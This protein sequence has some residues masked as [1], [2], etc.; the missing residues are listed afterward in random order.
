MRVLTLG[1]FDIPHYGH[2]RF[3]NKCRL[4]GDV[5][6]GLNTD[7]F[8][9]KYKGKKPIFSYQERITTLSEWGFNNIFPNNQSDGTIKDVIE[10][11][12]PEI[13]IIGSDWLRKDYLSQIGIDPDYLDDKNLSLI[14]VPYTWS[15]SSSEI[16]RRIE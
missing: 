14:Y 10:K 8:I 2:L 4:F 9:Q 11:T 1:T 15:I 3:L 16:K 5:Y 13:I 12:D 6:I 7:E